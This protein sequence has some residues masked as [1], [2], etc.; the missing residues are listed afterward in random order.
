MAHNFRSSSGAHGGRDLYHVILCGVLTV[1]R[2]CK[3]N[4]VT[5][6]L[7]VSTRQ[8]LH[9]PSTLTQW[10]LQ[11]NPRP[12]SRQSP[13]RRALHLSSSRASTPSAINLPSSKCVVAK[14]R[15]VHRATLGLEPEA[16][17]VP[18]LTPSPFPSPSFHHRS[19]VGLDCGQLP[20]PAQIRD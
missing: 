13:S 20:S 14:V 18:M 11:K 9:L 12:Q 5:L 4:A 19:Q 1:T 3:A 6:N 15:P 8:P 16:E 7:V 2:Y 17:K 10:L